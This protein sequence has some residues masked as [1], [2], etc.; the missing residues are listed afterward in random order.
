MNNNVY[1]PF[2]V[3]S[4][5][6]S[7]TAQQSIP[8]DNQNYIHA[9]FRF[10]RDWNGLNKTAIFQKDPPITSTA[11]LA[12]NFGD[13]AIHVPLVDDICMFPNEYLLEE[14]TISVSVY[15]SDRRTVNRVFVNV[16]ESG[17]MDGVPPADTEP[18]FEYVQTESAYA[19]T[20]IRWHSDKLQGLVGGT[21]IDLCCK[22]DGGTGGEEDMIWLPSVSADGTI[23]WTRSDSTVTP[24]TRNIM[25]PAGPTGAT[26]P[27]GEKGDQGL[28]GVA[29]PSGAN[30]APGATGPQGEKGETGPEGPKGEQGVQGLT[31]AAGKDGT[32]ITILGSFDS[33]ADLQTAHPTGNIGDAYLIAGELYVWDATNNKWN[34]VGSIQGPKGETGAQGPQ[35]IQGVAGPAGAKGETGATGT[36]G[37]QGIQGPKGDTGDDGP[38]GPA[39]A[40]GLTGATGPAGPTGDTGPAGPAGATGAA[41]A[42]GDTG[43]AGPT[44]PTGST[45]PEGPKGEQGIQG[46]TGP[47]GPTGPA[48]ADGKDGTGVTILGSYDTYEDFIAAHPTGTA[49]D[50]YLINGDLY[51]WNPNDLVWVNVGNIQG[52]A[53]PTGATGPQGTQGI[54][55]E[56]G[57][58][59]PAGPKGDTGPA[60]PTGSTGPAGAKGDTGLTGDT[61][62]A[63]PTGATGSTGPAGATGPTGLTGPTGSTGPQGIQGEKGETGPA[64][65]TGPTGATG[66]QGPQG[67]KGETGEFSATDLARVTALE[68]DVTTA[69]TDITNIKAEVSAKWVVLNTVETKANDN[70]AAIT[71]I[72]SDLAKV[73]IIDGGQI[74]LAID[75]WYEINDGYQCVSTVAKASY[76]YRAVIDPEFPTGQYITAPIEVTTDDGK[77]YHKTTT[78]PTGTIIGQLWFMEV[79]P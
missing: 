49:G 66:A 42:K 6:I 38:T 77:L 50:A 72:K 37:I 22:G 26:G 5:I 12:G 13:S 25:G 70:A 56:K 59:G 67:E 21:W 44:G 24:T 15:A 57:D 4:L 54:Q 73:G 2:N 14:G 32:G 41:G 76:L 10:T 31:G 52:P 18:N 62:P 53:G 69:K 40:Q 1:I 43:A 79:K 3:S 61:G 51:V 23:T 30:G 47:A 33:L 27:Q 36:Q 75:S 34:G 55:G 16:T 58:T 39:G 7:R 28:Q 63:G 71:T 9:K 8:V 64:G 11:T 45:G 60:G 17:Y 68:T 20:A 29:G 65:P 19:I 48:G 35:G 78:M 46:V 74:T